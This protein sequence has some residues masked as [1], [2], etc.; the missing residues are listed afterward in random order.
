MS[1]YERTWRKWPLPDIRYCQAMNLEGFRNTSAGIPAVLNCDHT[2]IYTCDVPSFP[3]CSTG[4]IWGFFCPNFWLNSLGQLVF[5]DCEGANN[6]E[7]SYPLRWE[8]IHLHLWNQELF[9]EFTRTLHW[10]LFWASWIHSI[11]SHSTPSSP[12]CLFLPNVFFPLHCRTR[13]FYSVLFSH[14]LYMS[15]SLPTSFDHPNNIS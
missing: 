7:N 12:L 6:T 11:P 2:R 15:S 10:T 13:I 5:A 14:P 1:E 3:K 9:T 4:L 8:V